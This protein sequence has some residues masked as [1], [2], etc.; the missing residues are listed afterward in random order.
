METTFN[1]IIKKAAFNI[2]NNKPFVMATVLESIGGTPC[3]S[4]F[5]MIVYSDGS[6]EGTVGGGLIEHKVRAV[7]KEIF[8]TKKNQF[9]Q[10]KLSELEN[11]E[12]KSEEGISQLDMQCGG[13]AKVFLEYYPPDKSI[14]LFGAGHLCQSILPILKSLQFH[15]VVIDNRQEYADKK[16]LQGADSVICSNYLQFAED[17]NPAPQDSVIIFT[18][19]HENDYDILLEICQRK[20]ELTYL[21]MIASTSKAKHNLQQLLDAGIPKE[22]VRCI[23]SPVGLNIAKT[24][25]QEIAISI[26]SELLAVYNKVSQIKSLSVAEEITAKE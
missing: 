11:P 21:G 22:Q 16:R 1:E 18:H 14:Y 3:R 15:T 9:L 25:T 2:Q 8:S 4:G 19:A 6:A 10:F 26:T 20:L 12:M 7:C 17:F 24:T 5:K 23:H 13:D